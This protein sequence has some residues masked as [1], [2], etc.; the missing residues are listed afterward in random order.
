MVALSPRETAKYYYI[1]S[2]KLIFPCFGN[3]LLIYKFKAKFFWF[4]VKSFS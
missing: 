1:V 2:L 4:V 3:N